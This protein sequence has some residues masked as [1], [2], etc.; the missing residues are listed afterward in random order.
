LGPLLFLGYVNDT[1]K[2]IVSTIILLAHD[3]VIYRKIV[4]N[5]DIENLDIGLGKLG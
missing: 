4:N 1:W 2:N 3:Y 5:N